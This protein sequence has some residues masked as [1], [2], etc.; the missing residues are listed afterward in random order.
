MEGFF[1]G[2]FDK[3]IN[4]YTLRVKVGVT[5]QS[6]ADQSIEEQSRANQSSVEVG[7][8][9]FVCAK[10]H[11]S[12]LNPFHVAIELIFSMTFA[13]RNE[14]QKWRNRNRAEKHQEYYDCRQK[15]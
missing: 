4:L 10:Q 15:K 3:L 2:R 7:T 12:R 13:R 8:S 5:E 11:F 14:S 1:S 6:R 9:L